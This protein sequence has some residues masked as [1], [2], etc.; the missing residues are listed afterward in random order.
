MHTLDVELEAGQMLS[1]IMGLSARIGTSALD[2]ARNA[3]LS[4]NWRLIF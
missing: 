4:V 3:T 1:A 2:S